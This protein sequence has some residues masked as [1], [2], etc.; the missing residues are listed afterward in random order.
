MLES[1]SMKRLVAGL[2]VS[3]LARA[4][5]A[6]GPAAPQ[7]QHDQ[8]YSLKLRVEGLFRQE[9]TQDIFV[10]PTETRDEDRWRLRVLP[11]LEIGINKLQ[12]GVGGDFNY[13]KDTNVTDPKPAL[14]RDN[15]DSRDARL[16]LA[17]ASFKPASWLQ[18]QGGRFAMPLALTEMIWDRDLRPQGATLTLETRDRGSLLRLGATGLWAKGSH[19][20]D[21]HETE[22]LIVSGEAVFATNP[23]S[24]IQLTGSWVKWR[25]L[26]ALEPMIRRQNSRL[27]GR[28]PQALAL[29]YSVLDGVARIRHEGK[30]STQIVADYCWNTA[31]DENNR[32]LWL[33]L[34]LGSTQTARGRFEYTYAK[35]DKDATLAAYA[36][37]D[38]FWGT[39]WEG[40][41]GDL[42]VRASDRSAFHAVGQIQRFYDSPRPEERDHWVKRLRLELRVSY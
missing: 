42:G 31:V 34:V 18:A 16:D 26:D 21:D 24:K 23:T 8:E 3:L 33:A 10:S 19:V 11:R 25:R 12:L 35:L 20:F 38:F 32:G 9:W 1:A 40:H 41:R 27:P 2:A 14:L 22:M 13:S 37:D 39:G 17:F 15:Y 28:P 30:V 7:Q 36:S 6:Q 5:A 4:A 29:G